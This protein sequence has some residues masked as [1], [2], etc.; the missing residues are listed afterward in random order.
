MRENERII[1]R[2]R[3]RERERE[4]F[5]IQFIEFCCDQVV[6]VIKEYLFILFAHVTLLA[7]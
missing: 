6:Y 7:M 1:E 4:I 3:E 5:Q 2:E